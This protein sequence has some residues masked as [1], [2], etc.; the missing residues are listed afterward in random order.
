MAIRVECGNC[1]FEY[2][3]QRQHAGKKFRCKHCGAILR[4]PAPKRRRRPVV[5]DFEDEWDDEAVSAPRPSQRSRGSRTSPLP[6]SRQRHREAKT[7]LSTGQLALIGAFGL[8]VLF[9]LSLSSAIVAVPFFLVFGVAA[10]TVLAVGI[11]WLSICNKPRSTTCPGP[12]AISMKLTRDWRIADM[13]W[14]SRF[15]RSRRS[16]PS[17]STLPDTVRPAR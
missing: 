6:S 9:G 1:S 5:E 11:G 16:I 7:G 8:C 17:E 13:L 2:D 14:N 3:I 10:I 4:V 15:N 12:T